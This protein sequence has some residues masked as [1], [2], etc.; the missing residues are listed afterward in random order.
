M[1]LSDLQDKEIIDISTGK[2][3]GYIIDV[4]V[5]LNGNISKLIIEDKKLNRKILT[6]EKDEIYLDWNKIVRIGD[7]IILI[8]K[9]EQK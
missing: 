1:N 6:K 2:R 7:D 3:I 9:K 8:D 4:I 5:N